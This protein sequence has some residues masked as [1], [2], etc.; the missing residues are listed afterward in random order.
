M[1]T[2]IIISS[3]P[4]ETRMGVLEDKVLREYLVERDTE[5]HLV[6]D[7]FLGRVCNVVPGLQAAFVDIGLEQN[8]FL[9]I[10]NDKKVTEGKAVLVQISKDARGSKGPT[11]TREVTIPGRY[12]VLV[13]DNDYIGISR[14][15]GGA[16]KREKLLDM[17]SKAKPKNVGVVV[18]TVAGSVSEEV[19]LQDL[20]KQLDAWQLIAKRMAVSKA[21]VLLYRELD[22]S[23]RIL[24]DYLN[25]TVDKI[26]IDS[27]EAYDRLRSLLK[28]VPEEDVRK[29]KLYRGT[30]D[31]FSY[32][33]LDEAIAS[34]SD[35]RVDLPCGGYI[36]IDHTEA[37]TVIDVNSGTYK[38]PSSLEATIM[39]TNREAAQ[40]IAYQLRLRDIGGI[41][42]VDFI[43]MHTEAHKDE[44]LKVLKDAFAGDK[45]RPKIQD[46]TVLNL[47]E[48]TRKK[49]RQNLDSVLYAPCPT[50]QGSGQVQSP[51][52]VAI[53]AKRRLRGI[54]K[55]QGASRDVLIMAHP[56][57]AEYLKGELHAWER[58]LNCSLELKDDP[59]LDVE[60]F[61][62][63]DNS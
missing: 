23:V 49:S 62:L 29:L 46:I 55:K 48:I 53:E 60:S 17:I 10:G 14:K 34:I 50:C 41:I 5:N 36:I 35:R 43:D 11:A 24:R 56:L 45:M 52:T 9:F 8:A 40:A 6:G 19:I 58:E 31:I 61:S 4:E 33:G 30:G 57:V 15:I 7:I 44:V 27:K 32:Y 26:T 63:L 28:G 18:R 38:D 3:T 12:V 22:L 1:T 39:R 51:E 37:M 59:L 54:L 16:T 20:Q 42:V 2:S 21:P 13:P 25:S 47:V